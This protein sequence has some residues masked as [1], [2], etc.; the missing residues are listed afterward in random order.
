[1]YISIYY[2]NNSASIEINFFYF[3]R[4]FAN[5]II[6][7]SPNELLLLKIILYNKIIYKIFV[8]LDPNKLFI[9]FVVTHYLANPFL[10]N[11]KV[12]SHRF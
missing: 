10:V 12:Y 9:D 11:L 3:F 7:S 5:F 8:T 1:M 2:L 6:P 4:A